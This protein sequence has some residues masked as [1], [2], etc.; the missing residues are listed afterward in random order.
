[1]V[2]LAPG[3]T[4]DVEYEAVNV[5][6]V[7][8]TQ[9][10]E[11]TTQNGSTTVVDSVSQTFTVG[12][13]S[14]GT[15][16]WT[17]SSPSDV[18]RAQLT[19]QS[20][21]TAES[22]EV[23]LDSEFIPSDIVFGIREF[24]GN[25]Y[26]LNRSNGSE[27]WIFGNDDKFVSASPAYGDGTV[28]VATR[29]GILYAIDRETGNEE[30]TYSTSNRPSSLLFYEGDVFMSTVFDGTVVSVDGS[31]GNE[32]WSKTDISDVDPPLSVSNGTVYAAPPNDGVYSI[33]ASTGAENWVYPNG[34]R[35]RSAPIVSDGFVYIGNSNAELFKLDVVDGTEDWVFTADDSVEKTVV[36]TSDTVFA[37]DNIGNMYSIDVQSGT[38]NWQTSISG[39]PTAPVLLNG[40]LYLSNDNGNI[41]VIDASDGSVLAD[42]NVGGTF[43]DPIAIGKGLIFTPDFQD[44]TY[45]AIDLDTRDIVWS[46][47]LPGQSRSPDFGGSDGVARSN[48]PGVAGNINPIGPL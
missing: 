19:I 8:S 11:L 42:E 4:I 3:E 47:S 13:T 34:F 41:V 44:E 29:G 45:K 7:D 9:T 24:D 26:S 32:N 38:Q 40:N 18:W 2:N 35:F 17:R 46:Y 12:Q 20:E 48:R 27:N 23:D 15:L 39:A 28:Y 36:V 30:W 16:S 31:T 22:L 6:D 37:P 14:T 25:I 5:G 10:L 1:M 43:N 33:D 21:N